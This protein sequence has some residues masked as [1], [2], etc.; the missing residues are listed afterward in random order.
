MDITDNGDRSCDVHDVT[1]P[2]EDLLCLLA[3][4]AQ[5]GLAEE[6]FLKELRD[7]GVDVEAAHSEERKECD[8]IEWEIR[9]L[10][11]GVCKVEA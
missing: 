8:T 2:H 3:D 11:L 1:L 6:T 9:G 7:A 10:V 4:L 5:E